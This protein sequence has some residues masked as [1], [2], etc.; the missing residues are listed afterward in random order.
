MKKMTQ[1]WENNKHIWNVKVF[2]KATSNQQ[3]FASNKTP[4]TWECNG[5]VV[6]NIKRGKTTWW[7]L[8][9]WWIPWTKQMPITTRW[10][11]WT[12]QALATTWTILVVPK[13]VDE[14]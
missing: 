2:A 1:F 13:I 10:M 8:A 3:P 9:T 11:S 12:K 14:H 4:S 6:P 5:R 7:A